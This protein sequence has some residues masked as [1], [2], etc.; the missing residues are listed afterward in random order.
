MN[1]NLNSNVIT[2]C[3]SGNNHSLFIVPEDII[4]GLYFL[5]R[6]NKIV[7]KV[8]NN[9]YIGYNCESKTRPKHSLC[10]SIACICFNTSSNKPVFTKQKYS[11]KA[12]HAGNKFS[13]NLSPSEKLY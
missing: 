12:H 13:V 1:S 4:N 9:R 7:M 10:V 3:M 11:N 2:L 8:A 5:E 6:N